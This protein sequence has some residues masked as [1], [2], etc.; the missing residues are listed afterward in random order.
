LHA[1]A[2]AELNPVK[3]AALYV[4]MN[5]MVLS[6]R[7]VTP[8]V[9]RPGVSTAMNNL[10]ASPKAWDSSFWDL[11]NWRMTAS[12]HGLRI[13]TTDTLLVQRARR[14]TYESCASATA[15]WAILAAFRRVDGSHEIGARFV[16]LRGRS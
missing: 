11:Q 13:R 2:E 4:Q 12:G 7:V 1:T 15:P 16:G 9:Y 14:R 6:R 5:D 10:R 8:I 3:R